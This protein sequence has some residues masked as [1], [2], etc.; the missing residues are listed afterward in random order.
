MSST[1]LFFLSFS[2]SLLQSTTINNYHGSSSL[3]GHI[4]P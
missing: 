2:L 1:L 3:F 4:D